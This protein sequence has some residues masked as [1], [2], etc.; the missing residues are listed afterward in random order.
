MGQCSTYL[1]SDIIL[2]TVIL[3]YLFALAGY[4]HCG[5]FYPTA[6]RDLQKSTLWSVGP[7]RDSS[8][9]ATDVTWHVPLL[10]RVCDARDFFA[11]KFESASFLP[12]SFDDVHD[13]QDDEVHRRIWRC[14]Q[15]YWEGRHW[16]ASACQ[17]STRLVMVVPAASSTGLLLKTT[18]LKVTAIKIDPYMNIDA[19]TMRPQEHGEDGS[20]AIG[21]QPWRSQV[22]LTRRGLC[23]ERWW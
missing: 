14:S 7:A 10:G 3:R 23:P 12:R 20:Y 8:A 18:G 13:N 15:W 11:K 6:Y 5:L 16:Y 4:C 21:I 2:E 19:G 1:P 9:S 17:L 22:R